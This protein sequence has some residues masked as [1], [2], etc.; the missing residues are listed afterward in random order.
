[1]ALF[2]SLHTVLLEDGYK[3]HVV[4]EDRNGR[5]L[6]VLNKTSDKGFIHER[7][8]MEIPSDRAYRLG[9]FICSLFEATGE[10][11]ETS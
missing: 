6:L 9:K 7:V 1:M 11:P 5:V 3:L 2:K 4:R 8:T 10:E